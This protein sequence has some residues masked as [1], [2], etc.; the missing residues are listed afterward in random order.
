MTQCEVI[1]TAM[2]E[3][4]DK[5][6]WTASD[7][8]GGNYFVGYEATARMSDL[9]RKYPNVFIVGKANRFRTL[10]INWEAEETQEL[11]KR[12]GLRGDA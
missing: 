4:K 2:L 9:K 11:L 8:Q 5:E 12:Y 10:T 6:V 3:N 7:F 1:L